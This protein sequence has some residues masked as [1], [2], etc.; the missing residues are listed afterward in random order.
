MTSHALLSRWLPAMYLAFL[1]LLA[2][3]LSYEGF[4]EPDTHAYL[5]QFSRLFPS[6]TPGMLQG[7][8]MLSAALCCLVFERLLYSLAHGSRAE[9][10][11]IFTGLGVAIA[12]LFKQSG[13]A[14]SANAPSLLLLLSGF[15]FGIRSLV[16]RHARLMPLAVLCCSLAI[17]T[18]PVFVALLLPFMV[19]MMLHAWQK[20]RY[21]ILVWSLIA[22]LPGTLLY[23]WMKQAG[24]NGVLWWHGWAVQNF[25]CRTFAGKGQTLQYLLPNLLYVLFP[26]AHPGF[27]IHL[28]LLLLMTKKTDVVL[29]E[30]KI[31]LFCTLTYL[32]LLGGLPFQQVSYLLP[33]YLLW[34]L[35]L[36]PSWDRIYCYGLIFF[37]KITLGVIVF[38]LAVQLACNIWM[39]CD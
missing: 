21:G 7:I 12:P 19:W 28:P 1:G 14:V 15:Y 25:F 22:L 36:F 26:L 2:A 17:V 4:S 6:F 27:L 33:V 32:L 11:W 34:L 23:L 24:F 29:A 38:T 35:V 13:L 10:R 3:G 8:S 5:Q 30:K 20:N 37:R 39:F 31:L 16:K 18:R 9:S